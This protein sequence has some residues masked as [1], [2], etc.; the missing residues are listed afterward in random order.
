MTDS[1]A[2]EILD[3]LRS[4]P[5]HKVDEVIDFAVFLS[6]RYGKGEATDEGNEWAEEDVHDASGA[7]HAYLGEDNE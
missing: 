1:Q 2:R 3:V 6:E 7:S 4:L 5:P